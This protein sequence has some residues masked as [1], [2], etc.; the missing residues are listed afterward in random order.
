MSDYQVCA[1]CGSYLY[2][3]AQAHGDAEK[4]R[5]ERHHDVLCVALEFCLSGA[6]RLPGPFDVEGA[7]AATRLIA[8]KLYPPPTETK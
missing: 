8:D 6:L 1:R 5:Q 4:L 7:V 3:Q 2:T